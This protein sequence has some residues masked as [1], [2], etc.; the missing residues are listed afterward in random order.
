MMA[1]NKEI[2]TGTQSTP[3]KIDE[4]SKGDLFAK[5]EMHGDKRK[6]NDN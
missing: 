3:W 5:H 6:T 1:S 4:D 2:T